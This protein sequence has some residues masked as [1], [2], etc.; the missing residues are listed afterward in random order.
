MIILDNQTTAMTGHQ[1]HPGVDYTP[2]GPNEH[3]V[4]IEAIV[5]ACGVKYVKK[6][7]PLNLKKTLEVLR[8]FKELKGVRVI[9][10][11]DPCTLFASRVLKK[12]QHTV[13]YVEKQHEEVEKCLKEL[14]CPAFYKKDGKILIDENLCSGCMFCVQITKF[15]KAKKK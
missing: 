15:I 11:E 13:A 14:A 3:R 6:V 9:I 4:D 2:F 10:A 12:K 8:E 5:K 1:P 7:K